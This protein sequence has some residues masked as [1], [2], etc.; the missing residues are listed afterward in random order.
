MTHII[1]S[2][3]VRDGGCIEVCPVDCIV[4]GDPDDG[5]PQ[6][7][8]DP[9]TCIDCGACIPECPYEAIFTEDE[10]PAAFE[11]A[12]GEYINRVGLSGHYEGEDAEGNPVV[13][14]TVKQLEA[15][16]VIDLTED[17]QPNYAFFEDGPGYGE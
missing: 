1:T 6:M 8:I 2:L 4:P 9:E 16:E 17:I 14:D 13:L 15:G 7:Y 3:C 5:W 10:V 12:G 11:A